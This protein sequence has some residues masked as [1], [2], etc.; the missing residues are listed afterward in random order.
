MPALLKAA[1]GES[2]AR[3]LYQQLSRTRTLMPRL[4]I[5]SETDIESLLNYW[6]TGINLRRKEIE[7]ILKSI[8]ST[9]GAPDILI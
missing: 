8:S 3:S 4:V 1:R 5:T 9:P 2:E 7:P 6:I